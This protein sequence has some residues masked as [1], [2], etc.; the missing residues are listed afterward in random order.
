MIKKLILF[1]PFLFISAAYSYAQG[2]NRVSIP[3]V[4]ENAKIDALLDKYVKL[5][6]PARSCFVLYADPI[7]GLY[8]LTVKGI[9]TDTSVLNV[10][11]FKYKAPFG[12]FKYRKFLVFVV[13][14]YDLFNFFEPTTHSKTFKY[15]LN[16]IGGD[17]YFCS[18]DY[19]YPIGQFDKMP[20]SDPIPAATIRAILITEDKKIDSLLDKYIGLNH[21]G[22]SCFLISSYLVNKEYSI[23]LNGLR[24]DTN[25]LNMNVFSQKTSLG[26]FRYKG[27]LVI[28]KLYAD[29]YHFFNMQGSSKIFRFEWNERKSEDK[30]LNPLG[31]SFCYNNYYRDKNGNFNS[32][33]IFDMV[34]L[35]DH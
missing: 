7:G 2:I 33:V 26:Y 18:A 17:K 1:I 16:A 5:G 32:S 30:E 4:K 35:K 27:Y 29:P 12:Y 14:T 20:F 28:V 8:G 9:K 23:S 19:N 34:P 22:K 15:R 6:D 21:P 24:T 10:N 31:Q 25:T 11:V 3:L 13:N